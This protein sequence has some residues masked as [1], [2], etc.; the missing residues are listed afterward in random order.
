MCHPDGDGEVVGTI[1]KSHAVYRTPHKVPEGLATA[2]MKPSTLRELHGRLGHIW[3][4]VLRTLLKRGLIKGVSNIDIEDDFECRA[5]FLA[6]TKR[7]SVPKLTDG[8][9]KTSFA[10]EIHSDLTPF[11]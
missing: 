4:D 10:D 3:I 2:V 6:K 1:P 8:E 9:R 7:K 11:G 5:C